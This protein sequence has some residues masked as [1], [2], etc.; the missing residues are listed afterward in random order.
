MSETLD[1]QSIAKPGKDLTLKKIPLVCSC[2]RKKNCGVALIACNDPLQTHLP[3]DSFPSEVRPTVLLG[4][5]LTLLSAS[6]TAC[7][8]LRL[9]NH[10]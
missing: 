2:N 7:G 8:R 3:L 4:S 1:S 5:T 9:A 6:S 10:D